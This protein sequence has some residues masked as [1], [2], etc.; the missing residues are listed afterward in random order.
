M[1]E[2]KNS[3]F[4]SCSSGSS[5]KEELPLCEQDDKC[6]LIN[7]RKHQRQF[8]HTCRLFPCYH[9]SM[10]SHA[11]MFRHA[12]GQLT[13]AEGVQNLTPQALTSVNFT[14]I[15]PDAP[16]AYLLYITFGNR[17]C[18][19]SGDWANVKVHTLKRYLNLVFHVAP[20]AQQLRVL[21]TDKIMDDE[22]STVKSYGVEADNIIEL[23]N[24]SV[25]DK[26]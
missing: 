11:K 7:D 10:A 15:S 9:S 3:S 16:N 1:E 8:A 18:G 5:G 6:P 4:I 12:P 17:S 25:G 13:G 14:S 19:V 2:S 20:A 22:L 23:T 24:T 21:K 26:P